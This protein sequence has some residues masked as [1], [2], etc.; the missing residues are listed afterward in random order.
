MQCGLPIAVGQE[1]KIGLECLSTVSG[2]C[3]ADVESIAVRPGRKIGVVLDE[4]ADP[5]TQAT[6]VTEIDRPSH[7]HIAWREC[8]AQRGEPI[9]SSQ[10]MFLD[11]GDDFTAS[12][13]DAHASKLR[14]GLAP[15]QWYEPRF[16]EACRQSSHILRAM[17]IDDDD[18]EPGCV[19][20][21]KD[22]G[23][24]V[25]DKRRP[26]DGGDDNR[27]FRRWAHSGWSRVHTKTP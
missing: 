1:S 25:V 24:T 17:A 5:I 2:V 19:L 26:N 13:F 21:T 18:L 6:V 20:L 12:L 10:A 15:R 4:V 8:S 14:H 3:A 11:D 22:R 9:V 23:Q 27:N 7:N 16:R